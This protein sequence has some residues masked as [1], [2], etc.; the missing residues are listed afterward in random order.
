MARG[1]VAL[2][3]VTTAQASLTTPLVLALLLP[4]RART[5]SD[6]LYGAWGMSY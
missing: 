6:P 2:T 1:C 5:T 3:P 4:A